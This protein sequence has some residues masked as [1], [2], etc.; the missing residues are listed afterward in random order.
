MK[1]TMKFTYVENWL[2]EYSK[3]MLSETQ[4]EPKENHL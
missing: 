4:L 3:N 2:E 1:F